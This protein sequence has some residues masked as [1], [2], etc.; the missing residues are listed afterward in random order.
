MTKP[1]PSALWRALMDGCHLI[2][3]AAPGYEAHLWRDSGQILTGEPHAEMNFA[4]VGSPPEALRHLRIFHER[5][6]ARDLPMVMLS[7]AATAEHLGVE[8]A[9]WGYV[10]AD[11]VPLM[12]CTEPGPGLAS[13][14][15]AIERIDDPAVLRAATPLAARTFGLPDADVARVYNQESL[16]VPGVDF[17]MARRSGEVWSFVQTSRI[18]T[19]VGIWSMA[20]APEYQGQGAGRALLQAVL[21]HH[22]RRGADLFYLMASSA[23][24]RL[25][26]GV[27]FQ[28]TTPL[29]S[30]L[31]GSSSQLGSAPVA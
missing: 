29:A 6:V 30:W 19:L 26:Q 20:T 14:P 12:V 8:A 4:F 21:A 17:F 27:G 13:H 2:C 5:A 10:P 15:Y 18:G 22:R 7:S 1:S 3:R 24:Q 9:S 23:G 28:E 25:Y 31:Y 16:A 11:E